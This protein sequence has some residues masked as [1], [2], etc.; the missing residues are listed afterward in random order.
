MIANVTYSCYYGNCYGGYRS[1]Y[2][3]D[4]YGGYGSCYYNA[5][6]VVTMVTIIAVNMVIALVT[7]AVHVTVIVVAMAVAMV[8]ATIVI[9]SPCY[10]LVFVQQ[11]HFFLRK[12]G[13]VY[14]NNRCETFL[15]NFS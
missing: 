5:S 10:S 3:G 6:V 12:H 15:D 7:A 8:T 14:K 1:C 13:C 9:I 4:Y 11:G 2:Y